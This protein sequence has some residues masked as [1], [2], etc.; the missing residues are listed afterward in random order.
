[1]IA[2][3]FFSSERMEM[4]QP[5]P[6]DAAL[7]FQRYSSLLEVTR[8]LGWPRHQS[9]ADSNAFI[10]F[11]DTEWENNHL[12]PLLCF[13]RQSG[14]L[15]GSAGLAMEDQ[16]VASTGCVI[17]PGYWGQG[18]GTECLQSMK[19]LA[20]SMRLLR[21]LAFVHPENSASIRMIEKCGFKRDRS[22]AKEMVFPNL[23]R[24]PVVRADGY[25]WDSG[26][27]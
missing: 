14:E 7:I 17:A 18:F 27:Y 8:F 3:S 23:P 24:A 21:L 2:N 5:V 6:E 4:R 11:S 16:R 15:I 20:N 22:R 26:Q 19:A 12:G 10:R 1:M 9:L 13:D 25:G